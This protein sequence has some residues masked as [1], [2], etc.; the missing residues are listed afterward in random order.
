MF[1]VR[2]EQILSDIIMC[3][4]ILSHISGNLFHIVSYS[5]LQVILP[6]FFLLL[7]DL[8]IT[9]FRSVL[10]S[11]N[12]Q[13]SQLELSLAIS[14]EPTLYNT[15]KVSVIHPRHQHIITKWGYKTIILIISIRYVNHPS[16][17]R[18]TSQH[19][20]NAWAAKDENIEI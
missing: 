9:F 3:R 5:P 2:Y 12:H 15:I 8:K 4:S 13:T 20:N 7:Q 17:I 16:S 6:D 10:S 11:T 18:T 1:I 19:F 14:S